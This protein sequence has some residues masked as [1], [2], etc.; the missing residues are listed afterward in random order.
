MLLSNLHKGLAAL[1]LLDGECVTGTCDL[2]R[3]KYV[4]VCLYSASHCLSALI[5]SY[6]CAWVTSSLGCGTL[7]WT[8]SPIKVYTVK[9][10][11]LSDG[12][13]L[14]CHLTSVTGL[15]LAFSHYTGVRCFIR[16][17]CKSTHHMLLPSF[18][19][20]LNLLDHNG[21]FLY[22]GCL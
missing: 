15:I 6:F 13:R 22:W 20:E 17:W 8:T 10:L 16:C 3:W 2:C 19:H 14:A 21:L 18:A 5:R 12:L 4:V 11:R 7:T 1:T 9:P